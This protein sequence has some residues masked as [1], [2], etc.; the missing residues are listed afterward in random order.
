MS[1]EAILA[2]IQNAQQEHDRMLGV[3]DSIMDAD[4]YHESHKSTI[5][6]AFENMGTLAKRIGELKALL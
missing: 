4:Y 5:D 2:E 6:R 3:V 1:R